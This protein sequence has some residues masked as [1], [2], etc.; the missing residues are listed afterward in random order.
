MCN[1]TDIGWNQDCFSQL[2]RSRLLLLIIYLPR[3]NVS[4]LGDS[5]KE[6]LCRD[7]GNTVVETA[8]NFCPAS[9]TTPQLPALRGPDQ[10]TRTHGHGDPRCPRSP[11]CCQDPPAAPA[12]A[13]HPGAAAPEALAEAGAGFIEV[14][15]SG[16]QRFAPRHRV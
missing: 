14:S 8:S 6:H 10:P 4:A 13:A 2:S 15:S 3:L 5:Y 7:P 9:A 1:C 12:A 16:E 11:P